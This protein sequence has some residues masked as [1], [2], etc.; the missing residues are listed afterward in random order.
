MR[1]TFPL[2]SGTLGMILVIVS[3]YF[4]YSSQLSNPYVHWSIIACGYIGGFLIVI[5]IYI[6]V[7]RMKKIRRMSMDENTVTL[8]WLIAGIICSVA[9]LVG[10]GSLIYIL[11][12]YFTKKTL[13]SNLIAG[14][15]ISIIVGLGG[16][17][18]ALSRLLP[19]AK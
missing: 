9:L 17:L 14:T 8:V 12:Y 1:N 15:I 5:T 4:L 3:I 7:I 10:L 18:S 16:T 19:L 6:L 2:F 13:H 11:Y